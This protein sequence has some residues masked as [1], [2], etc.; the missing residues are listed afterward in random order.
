MTKRDIVVRIAT[1]TGQNQRDV[2]TVVQMTLDQITS[3]LGAGRRV[4]LRNFA[5]RF[6]F[7]H[8]N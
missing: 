7:L 5:F 2:A 8:G 3:E 1:E 4:E 6:W